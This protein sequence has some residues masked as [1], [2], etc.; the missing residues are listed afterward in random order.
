MLTSTWFYRLPLFI[1][2][3]APLFISPYPPARASTLQSVIGRH[4]GLETTSPAPIRSNPVYPIVKMI[5]RT[6]TSSISPSRPDLSRPHW[7][8][9]WTKFV[10]RWRS[11]SPPRAKGPLLAIHRFSWHRRPTPSS[12]PR[13]ISL[14]SSPHLTAA[15]G[16]ASQDGPMHS[17]ST[18][19]LATRKPA[20]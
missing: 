18:S 10:P 14:L 19:S 8:W 13:V 5:E 9:R 4:A 6:S 20:T 12:S 17:S 1:N 2:Y 15:R 11:C 3:Q 7:H 16:Q